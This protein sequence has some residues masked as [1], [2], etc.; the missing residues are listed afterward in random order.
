[1]K[2]I[3]AFLILL[4]II[5]CAKEQK[6]TVNLTNEQDK[7][8]ICNVID[9]WHKNAAEG[10]YEAY[11]N[12]M[13]SSSVFIGTD[14]S[15]NWA[16]SEFKEFS[17]PHFADGLAWDFKAINRN[18]YLAVDNK[19]AWFDELLNTWMGVC[20]GSGVLV[21][22]NDQWKIQH[23]VLSVTVPNDNV[24]E[25]IKINKEKDSLFLKKYLN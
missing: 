21:K 14:A 4:L 6:S 12:S 2:K 3:S 23:Y 9:T 11:F 22:E 24:L 10:N 20:R 18:V 5:A 15:E 7:E 16:V 13:T 8:I 1:M 19:T 17:K 25:V